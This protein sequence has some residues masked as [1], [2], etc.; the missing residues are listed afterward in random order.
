ML[1]TIDVGN[2]NI[3]AGVFD[4][5]G[6]AGAASRL[7]A[8]SRSLRIHTVH[9]K[10]EDEYTTIFRSILADRGVDPSGID[11]VVLGSVVPSL[12]EPMELMC[13]R[14]FGVRPA[15]L[16][17][18]I[19]PRLPLEIVPDPHE[20]GADLV[21][22]ALAAWTRFGGACVVVDFGTA[23]TLTCVSSDARLLGV[24]IAPG[25]GT[26]VN[27]LSR[28]TAQLPFVQLAA[29]S[30]VIGTNSKL[31]IQ[32]GVVLGYVGLVEHLVR[33][34]KAEIGADAK[35]IATGG[36]CST[37]AGLATCFDAVDADLTLSGL[38][39]VAGFLD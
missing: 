6:A 23:L 22:D 9:K 29:P 34:I 16:G 1:L 24:S 8:P 10:T 25:L 7:P 36:L 38:A 32:S 30:S 19:Y 21:A 2:T 33:L 18:A 4:G 17:P 14:L 27:A 3:C 15:T 13:E 5:L 12:I 11:R 37:M 20:I 31:S 28:D 35:V 39:L 26:A